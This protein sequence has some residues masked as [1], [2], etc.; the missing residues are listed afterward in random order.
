MC[1][2]S[3][4]QSIIF[5]RLKWNVSLWI[6]SRT[7]PLTM[8]GWRGGQGATSTHNPHMKWTENYVRYWTKCLQDS[9]WLN[10]QKTETERKMTLFCTIEGLIWWTRY[11]KLPELYCK[12]SSTSKVLT[13]SCL[14]H[15]K[16][17]TKSCQPPF[18]ICFP[19]TKNAAH[20]EQKLQVV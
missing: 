8:S 15:E 20:T 5:Q 19:P 4:N 6:A 17:Q 13:Q 2:L 7:Y 3:W 16:T 12:C 10:K 14:Q 18:W 9:F 1:K 11:P